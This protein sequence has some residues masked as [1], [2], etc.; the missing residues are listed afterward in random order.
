MFLMLSS[1]ILGNLI[2]TVDNFYQNYTVFRRKKYLIWYYLIKNKVKQFMKSINRL[3]P[4]K[5]FVNYQVKLKIR[6]LKTIE[7]YRS[8]KISQISKYNTSILLCSSF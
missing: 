8:T 5:K 3:N 6:E 2:K 7:N 4:N 1:M